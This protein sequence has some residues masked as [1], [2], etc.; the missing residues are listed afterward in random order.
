MENKEGRD[1]GWVLRSWKGQAKPPFV[2]Y[3]RY[4]GPDA[5]SNWKT[6]KGFSWESDVSFSFE[7]IT[8]ATKKK[9]D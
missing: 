1:T 7:N 2:G 5:K 8:L 3:G 4:T 9:T 6:I